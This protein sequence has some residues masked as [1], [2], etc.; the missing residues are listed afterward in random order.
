MQRRNSESWVELKLKSVCILFD[1]RLRPL[2][3]MATTS[4]AANTAGTS[5]KAVM[6]AVV[7]TG[8]G[9][10]I[11]RATALYLA[12]TGKYSLAL[13]DSDSD[14]GKA[15]CEEL[16]L[17]HPKVDIVFAAVDLSVEENVIKLF[18]SFRKT[19]GTLHGLVNCAGINLTS[20]S[21]THV[22]AGSI[23]PKLMA[24]NLHSALFCSTQFIAAAV[25]EKNPSP[26]PVGG[27]S[28]VNFSASR[29]LPKDAF[30]S[31][32]VR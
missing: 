13:V 15:L 12:E 14:D 11:G 9:S 26:P 31:H 3:K 25:S 20:D 27:Y 29:N 16:H 17:K 24:N 23:L 4:A 7:I 28:I 10:G 6:S 21:P 5:G 19:F 1:V 30:N 18:R 32:Y 8:A 22:L 2:R